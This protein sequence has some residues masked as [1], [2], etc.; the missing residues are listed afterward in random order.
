MKE[1]II[2]YDYIRIVA[3][4]LVVACHCFGD[5]STASPAV[6]SLLSYLEMP[7]NGLFFAISGALLLPVHTPPMRVVSG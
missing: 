1:R 2:A 3:M 6:I 4:L 5:T 7:C